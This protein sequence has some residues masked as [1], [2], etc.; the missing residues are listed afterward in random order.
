MQIN[1][2]ELKKKEFLIIISIII[3]ISV[4]DATV[5][6]LSIKECMHLTFKIRYIHIN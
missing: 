6:Q 4:I 3:V 5:I 1:F 2:T